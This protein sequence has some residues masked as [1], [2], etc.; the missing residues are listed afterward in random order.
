MGGCVGVDVAKSHLDGVLG[1]DGEVERI[2]NGPASVRRLVRK[3]HKLD[4]DRVVL[5]STG[6]FE[7]IL[8]EALEDSGIP[9]Y[10][11]NPFR[12]RR[13]GEGMGARAKNDSIDAKLLAL[14]GE[15]AEPE[16]RPKRTNGERLI[17]DL[18]AR[19]RQLIANMTAEKNRLEHASGCG[20][21]VIRSL[22]R[23]LE[24][25]I[26]RLEGPMDHLI[27]KDERQRQDFARL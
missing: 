12:V 26:E 3:L 13:F 11:I 16:E 5:E 23:T 8:F 27:A 18:S 24:W 6:Q 22:V 7:R 9:A 21:K 15:K 10:R 14:V 20:A 2:E 19:R 25:H 4:F 17:G 1:P